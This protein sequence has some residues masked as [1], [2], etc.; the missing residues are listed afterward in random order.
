MLSLTFH[1]DNANDNNNSKNNYHNLI[2]AVN[3]ARKKKGNEVKL[4]LIKTNFD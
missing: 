2:V 4:V 3:N 1:N